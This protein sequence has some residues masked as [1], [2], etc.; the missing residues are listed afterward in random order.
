M[1]HVNARFVILLLAI[2][3]SACGHAASAH[4]GFAV[5]DFGAITLKNGNVV[6]KVKGHD[7]ARVGS[8][9]KL[10]IGG[11]E[12]AVSPPAQAA[13]ARYN[14]D[15]VVFTEQAKNLGLD[16]A[17]FALH[18]IGQVF[19]GIFDGSADQAGK[20]ADQGSQVIEAR[21]RLLC[22][23][24]DEWRQAQDAAAAAVPEFRPYAVISQDQARN[25]VDDSDS[26]PAR[27]AATPQISS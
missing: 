19:K 14:A 10:S 15:A 1:N 23:R 27:S 2:S 26:A 18:T 24:M 20:E 21:A 5:F 9:G 3:F 25:C 7:K 8:D 17:D 6:I 16:S 22:R 4:H 13:L 11:N 12:V